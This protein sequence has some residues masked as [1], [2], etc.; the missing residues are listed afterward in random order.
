MESAFNAEV[1]NLYGA[2]ESLALGVETG[3]DDG[4][5]LFD[6]MNYIEV[7]NKTMYLTSLYNFVQPLIRYRIS[8]QLVIRSDK[9]E[10]NH[11]FSVAE[12]LLGRNEDL[13]WFED[14][15]GNKEFLHPLA[16]EGFCIDGLLDFQFHQTGRASFEMLAEVLEEN[17]KENIK[18][19]M[20]RQM[21]KILQEK[22]LEYIQF[23]VQFVEEILPDSKTGKKKLIVNSK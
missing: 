7:E 19:E 13:L 16:I 22:Q 23:T 1:V 17:K 5:I 4:M 21:G 15:K 11:P 6:D 9:D 2:S 12:I 8:D 14:E 18:A 10:N 20:L 3:K